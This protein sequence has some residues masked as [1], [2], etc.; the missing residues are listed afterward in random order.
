MKL[1]IEV[2]VNGTDM[3]VSKAQIIGSESDDEQVIADRC[4]KFLIQEINKTGHKK[5]GIYKLLKNPG[6]E[7]SKSTEIILQYAFPQSMKIQDVEDEY[8]PKFTKDIKPF[9]YN[10][11]NILKN[12]VGE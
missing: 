4:L 2:D 8:I 7:L 5:I 12:T 9:K 1:P 10:Q 11:G 6:I 3:Y